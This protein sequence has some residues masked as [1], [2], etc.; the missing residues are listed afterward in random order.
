MFIWKMKK[1][2]LNILFQAVITQFLKNM[3]F[4]HFEKKKI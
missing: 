2:K 3:S 1:L 4:F